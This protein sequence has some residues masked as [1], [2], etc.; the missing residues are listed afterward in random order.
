MQ[1]YLEVQKISKKVHKEHLL[2]YLD[3]YINIKISLCRFLPVIMTHARP[4]L[5]SVV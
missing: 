3:L 1:V 2:Y 4:K 5:K